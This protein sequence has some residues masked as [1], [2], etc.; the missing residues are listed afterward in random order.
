M[1]TGRGV[2]GDGKRGVVTGGVCGEGRGSAVTGG[3]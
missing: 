1:V 2:C 3:V